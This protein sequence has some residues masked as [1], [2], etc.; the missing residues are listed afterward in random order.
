MLAAAKRVVLCGL[1]L[2][3]CM[4]GVLDGSGYGS[5]VAEDTLNSILL[6]ENYCTAYSHSR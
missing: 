2:Q 5:G 4:D 6:Q 3:R 1:L